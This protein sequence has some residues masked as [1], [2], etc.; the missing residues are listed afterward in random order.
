MPPPIVTALPARHST[1]LRKIS[2]LTH[3]HTITESRDRRAGKTEEVRAPRWGPC[4]RA[5]RQ[6]RLCRSRM[7]TLTPRFG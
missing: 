5:A 3:P 6:P 4:V 2:K 1:L 7:Q